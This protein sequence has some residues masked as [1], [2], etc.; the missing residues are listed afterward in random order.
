MPI[1]TLARVLQ[2]AAKYQWWFYGLFGLLVLFYLGRAVRARR[3]GARS[4]FRLEQEQAR[5]RYGRSV[6]VL[7]VVLFC[8]GTVFGLTNLYLPTLIRTPE[9]TATATTGP[10]EQPT[11]TPTPVRPTVTPTTTATRVSP[12]RVLPSPTAPSTSTP[13]VRPPS[14]PDSNARLTSPGMNQVVSTSV[15]VRGTANIAGFWKYKVEVGI[16]PNPS[17]WQVVGQEHFSPVVNDV[18][19]TFNSG[20]YPPGV[21]TLQ[22]TVADTTGNYPSPCQVTI[23]VQH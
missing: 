13:V 22:L 2:F 7:A 17:S 21:Y 10:L 23:T 5:G 18:L 20:D 9:P 11:L 12:T 14:C 8:T 1:S 16:G 3:E 4:L 6:I 15:Q 19:E